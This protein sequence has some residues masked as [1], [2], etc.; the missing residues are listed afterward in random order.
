MRRSLPASNTFMS[1]WS[2]DVYSIFPMLGHYTPNHPLTCTHDCQYDI[3]GCTFI[4]WAILFYP[5]PNLHVNRITFCEWNIYVNVSVAVEFWT[6]D[7]LNYQTSIISCEEKATAL[8]HQIGER[9][10]LPSGLFNG[11]SEWLDV[12]LPRPTN[13]LPSLVS[14]CRLVACPVFDRNSDMFF[15]VWIYV[16]ERK[17]RSWFF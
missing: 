13:K 9:C 12:S 14:A 16:G 17:G 10:L 15:L 11:K 6:I 1:N 3:A 4:L 2:T 5:K 8:W 7:Q